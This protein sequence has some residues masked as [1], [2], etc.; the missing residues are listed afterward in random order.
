MA[1]LPFPDPPPG[2][3]S[4]LFLADS[5]RT[6]EDAAEATMGT[7]SLREFDTACSLAG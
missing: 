7:P 5:G 6:T 2:Q 4:H 1:Q 3:E